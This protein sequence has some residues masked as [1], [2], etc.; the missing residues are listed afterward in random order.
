MLTTVVL[1]AVNDWVKNLRLKLLM[2]SKPTTGSQVVHIGSTTY[3]VYIKSHK[4]CGLAESMV[5]QFMYDSPRTKTVLGIRRVSDANLV[6]L[7]T[8]L[9]GYELVPATRQ[10]FNL[11]ASIKHTC[12]ISRL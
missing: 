10:T 3:T 5:Y 11:R 4:P 7:L 12:G 9:L 1:I 6:K 2:G 8:A